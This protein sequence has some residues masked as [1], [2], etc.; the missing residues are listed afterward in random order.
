MFRGSFV[1]ILFSTIRAFGGNLQMLPPLPNGASATTIQVDSAGSIY[2]AGTITPQNPKTADDTADAFV[3]KLSPDAS[4]VIYSTV[5]SGSAYDRIAAIALGAD[6]SVY[7][8]GYTTSPDFPTT[9]GAH[10]A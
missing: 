1:L 9:P 2:V 8:T 7:A 3:M 10:A 6:N 5:L 4:Q